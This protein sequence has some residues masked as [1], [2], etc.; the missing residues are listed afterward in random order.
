LQEND[1]GQPRRGQIVDGVHSA[2]SILPLMSLAEAL[3]VIK[4][5]DVDAVLVANP[6]AYQT[7]V[8]VAAIAAGKHVLIEKLMSMTNARP[9]QSAPPKTAGVIVQVGYSAITLTSSTKNSVGRIL[10]LFA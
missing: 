4:I 2:P 7:D 1:V 3:E 10:P 5:G 9:T 6:N 8:A